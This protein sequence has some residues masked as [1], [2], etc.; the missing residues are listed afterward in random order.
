MQFKSIGGS[1]YTLITRHYCTRWTRVEYLKRKSDAADALEKDLADYRVKCVPCEV[2]IAR[3][4]NGRE[5]W[6]TFAEIYGKHGIKQ[7]FTPPL[8]VTFT[9]VLPSEDSVLSLMPHMR[10]EFKKRV[11]PDASTSSSLWAE[12]ASCHATS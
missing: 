10:R 8:I 3:S 6:G 5:F 7:E 4:G 11:F 2:F 1:W 12:S 9:T